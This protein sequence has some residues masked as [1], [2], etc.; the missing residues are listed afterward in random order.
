[1][2]RN[3]KFHWSRILKIIEFIDCSQDFVVSDIIPKDLNSGKINEIFYVQL[4]KIFVNIDK[5]QD[6]LR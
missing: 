3:R 1:M 6:N 5:F 4:K 2:A